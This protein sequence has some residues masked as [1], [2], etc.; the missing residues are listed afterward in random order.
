M[1]DDELSRLLGMAGQSGP[2]REHPDCLMALSPGSHDSLDH[3]AWHWRP[4]PP[5]LKHLE[6]TALSGSPNQLS[7]DHH[8]WPVIDQ[9]AES[10]HKPVTEA[11]EAGAGMTPEVPLSRL[12]GRAMSARTIFRGRR[13]AVAMDGTTWID[14]NAFFRM[15]AATMPS[16]DRPPLD[17]FLHPPA[18]HLVLFVH[19]VFDIE[20]G[21]YVLVRNPEDEEIL[22]SNFRQEFEADVLLRAAD[23][24]MTDFKAM[25]N[26]PFSDTVAGRFS[27]Q[28]RT[29]DGYGH[30][31]LND[32]EL[33][34]LDSRQFLLHFLQNIS[35]SL[36]T[37]RNISRHFLCLKIN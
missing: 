8:P 24:G 32:R 22:R 27:F 5:A 19:R 31:V 6:E 3:A 20:P 36:Q 23:Y 16:R 18:H 25:V 10:C 37:F 11:A 4:P 34:N 17:S 14:G 2:E 30:D 26:S 28:S 35:T 29:H 13:S 12:A 9:I 1:S 21:L 7:A 33:D 15:L